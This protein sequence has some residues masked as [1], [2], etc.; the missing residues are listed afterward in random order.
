METIQTVATRW[1]NEYTQM[2]DRV[3]KAG[4]DNLSFFGGGYEREGGYSLQQNPEEFAAACVYLHLDQRLYGRGTYLEIGSASGGACRFLDEQLEFERA[5]V[6]DNHG[7]HRWTEQ[8]ANFDE[9][10]AEVLED[11]TRCLVVP[12]VQKWVGDS[13]SPTC[14]LWLSRMAQY[15][16]PDLSFIDGDHTFA[17]C[18]SDLQLVNDVARK[19]GG[20]VMFHDIVACDGVRD[21]WKKGIEAGMF[22]PLAE[23]VGSGRALGIGIGMFSLQSHGGAVAAR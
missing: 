13:A 23:F 14:R 19:A 11:E 7:H 6:I 20:L 1:P 12:V 9:I 17:G 2:L 10:G 3:R 21:T 18:W 22:D 15:H 5:W 8:Q 4:T 16:K